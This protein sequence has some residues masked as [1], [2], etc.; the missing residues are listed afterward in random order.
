MNL[1][2]ERK[3]NKLIC[4]ILGV[5]GYALHH[6]ELKQVTLVLHVSVQHDG[7]HT[8]KA[9]KKCTNEINFGFFNVLQV[10]K[11]LCKQFHEKESL[12]SSFRYFNLKWCIF[13]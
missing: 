2:L 5:L 1:R 11:L 4:T 9:Q 10:I 3:Q 8:P 12:F 6:V 13:S 7:V